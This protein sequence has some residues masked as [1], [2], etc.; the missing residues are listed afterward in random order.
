MAKTYTAA[1]TVVAGDVYTAAAHN[2]IVT[3]V[4]NLIV[5]PMARASRS[6]DLSIAN[7]T[8]TAVAFSVEDFDTDGM[9]TAGNAIMTIQT[10]G[11]YLVTGSAG[12]QI[13]PTGVRGL[14][15]VRNPT[16]GGSNAI[17]AGLRIANS[18]TNTVNAGATNSGLTVTTLYNFSASDTVCVGIY[19]NAGGPLSVTGTTTEQPSLSVTWIGQTA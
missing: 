8:A 16:I 19:Q 3:D 14:F 13:H 11:V 6:T 1:G 4:N 10:A 12:V 7:A 18:W 15:L 9:Y 2:I 5:K 17:T